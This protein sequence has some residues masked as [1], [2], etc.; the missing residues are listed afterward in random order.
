MTNWNI[1][2]P[3]FQAKRRMQLPNSLTLE[4]STR[5]LW[6]LWRGFSDNHKLSNFPPLKM[7]NSESI[8]GFAS[9]ISSMVAVLKLLGYE[10]DLKSK[11]VLNQLTST[12][13]PNKKESWY[14]HSVKEC[15]RQPIVLDLMTGSAI[16]LRHMN[17]CVSVRISHDL[18]RL[19]RLISI[20]HP[21]IIWHLME[22]HF[23]LRACRVRVNT[24]SGVVLSNIEIVALADPVEK[25]MVRARIVW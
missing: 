1:S 16:E 18:R 4:Y 19:W 14:L 9:C 7:H 24:H 13:P 25:I 11:S 8:I 5:T 2:K 22:N 12:L 15:W 23:M 3:S 20:N 6:K 17:L 10:Y 21:Q